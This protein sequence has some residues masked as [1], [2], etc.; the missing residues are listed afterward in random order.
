MV[1]GIALSFLGCGK[2]GE[3]GD[4]SS[5]PSAP[6]SEAIP[7][8]EY[9][10][11]VGTYGGQL[12]LTNIANPKSFNPIIAQETSTTSITQYIFDGLTRVSGI[13]NEPEPA[14]AERWEVGPDGLTWTIHLRKDV[15]WN[16]GVPF[17]A[18]DVVFTYRRLVYNKDI[19][20]SSRD[21]FTIEG[22]E[23]EV[24]KLDAHTVAFKT[25]M[26][27]A[28]FLRGLNQEILPKH[29]LEESVD[30]GTF[31]STWGVDSKLEDIVGT[32]PFM[33]ERYEASQRVI[34]KRNPHYWRTD[35]EG[36]RLPYLD[37]ITILIVPDIN[38]SLLKFQEG[39]SDFYGLRGEDYPTLKPLEREKNF[40]I[41]R[42]GPAFGTNFLVFNQ[43]PGKNSETRK[44]YI[45]PKKLKW[46]TDARFR[47]AVAYALDRQSMINVVLNGLGYLQHASMSPSAG[48]FYNPNVVKY[49][50][51]PEKARRILT[52][53]GFRDRNGDGYV[54]DSEGNKVEFNLFTNAENNVR[55]M[56][57][58]IIRKDLEEI[59]M[60]VHFTPLEFNNL[61]D[62]LMATF[63]WD[64]ILLG[65]TGGVE[66]HFG[67]NV[68]HSSGQLH[69]W[70]PRQKKPATEWEARIDKIFDLAVQELDPDKRKE[71]YDEWQ[72]IV[73]EQVPL[74]YTVLPE[75]I[76]AVRNKFGNLYPTAF[77]GAFHNIEEIYVS[78]K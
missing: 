29:R 12:I 31:N 3:V 33:L 1:V 56:I 22:K 21:I 47:Q 46:F 11:K 54:E 35:K 53:A 30:K 60:Q 43:N 73:S 77:G 8:A 13:T 36:N 16:D 44:L 74:I 32:G 2:K 71:L 23:F 9:T 39:E 6:A 61:V 49:D 62:K 57:G 78:G 37:G 5:R 34:L 52:E 27:F 64:C 59:G 4:K 38:V 75:T 67:K 15:K 40:R 7:A 45:D 51:D 69:E 20:T 24:T 72:L 58:D 41:F 55:V 65:L 42:V 17:T 66:P 25:P 63:D 10:P 28:P 70:Y 19:P 18:D 50:Y 76:F 68:W 48:F 14:L 26:K